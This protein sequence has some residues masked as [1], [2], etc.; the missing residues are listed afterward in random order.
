MYLSMAACT[1][2][3]EMEAVV[4]VTRSFTRFWGLSMSESKMM[5]SE[6]Y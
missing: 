1:G 4:S 2:S 5:I 6:H 3:Q